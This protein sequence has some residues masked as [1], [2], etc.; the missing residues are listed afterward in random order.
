MTRPQTSARTSGRVTAWFLLACC[1]AACAGPGLH[2]LRRASPLERARAKARVE[3]GIALLVEAGDPSGA[4]AAFAQALSSDPA[5]PRIRLWA[6]WVAQLE[7]DAEGAF[8]HFLVAAQAPDPTAELAIW[9]AYRIFTTQGQAARLARVL[10]AVAARTETPALVRARALH[11]LGH[12]LR[13]LGR[14]KAADRAFARLGYLRAW[15]VIGPFDNDQNAGFHTAYPPE[16]GPI[17]L[18]QTYPGK[19]RQVGWRPVVLFAPDGRVSL[20]A[21]LDPSRWATAYLV[22]WIHSPEPK[23]VAIRLAAFR[24]VKLWLNSEP[25]LADD[26]ARV[27]ALDQYAVGARLRAGWNELLVKVCQRT[28]PW[29]LGLRLTAPDGDPVQGLRTSARA[30]PLAPAQAEGPAPATAQTFETWLSTQPADDFRAAVS[31][32]WSLRQGFSPEATRRAEAWTQARPA[33]PLAQLMLAQ[34]H[35]EAG[36]S[37][38]ALQ[39][40]AALE[41]TVAALPAALLE[42]SGYEQRNR[43]YDRA[44]RILEPLLTPGRATPAVRARQVSLLA[45]RGWHLDALREA[46]AL[47]GVQPDRAW[48]WRIIGDQYFDLLQTA[49][50]LAAYRRALAL[51]ADHKGTYDRLI[52]SDILAGRLASA[53]ALVRRRTRVFPELMSAAVQEARLLMA[54]GRPAEAL[55]VCD[56]IERIAPDFWFVH[57][58]RGDIFFWSRDRDGALSAYR[59]SLECTPNNPA[60]QEYLHHLVHQPDPVFVRYGPT[61]GELDQALAAR[62]GPQDYPEADAVLMLDDLVTHVFADGS[63]RHLV[64][65]IYRV[66]TEKGQRRLSEFRVPSS[67]SFRLEAAETIGPD[68]S[69]QEATSISA[70]VIHLPS[71]QPGSL[72]YVA[73][74]Y[75]SSSRTWMEDHYADSFT[76]QGPDPVRRARWVLA[77]PSDRKLHM[78]ERGRLIRRRMEKAGDQQVYVWTASDV[79]MLHAEPWRPP[80]RK[81]QS[82]VYVSTVP[83]WAALARWHNS[84]LQDQFEIDDA[85]R[86]KA[87]ELVSGAKTAPEKI[88]AIYRFVAKQI[89]YLD[90]DVGIFGKKPNQA[91]NVFANRFGDCKDKSTLMIAM[92]RQLGIQAYYAAVRT[93]DTGPVFWQVPYAQSNHIITFI[94]AQPGVAKP[95]FVDPTANHSDMGYLPERDQDVRALVLTGEG[96][97]LI[98]TPELGPAASMRRLSIDARIKDGQRL[99]MKVE[100]TWSGWFATR[101]RGDLSTEGKRAEDFARKVSARYPGAA[102]GSVRFSGL[103]D[104]GPEASARYSFEVPGALRREDDKLRLKLLWPLELTDRMARR[105]RRRHAFWNIWDMTSRVEVRFEVP[106]GYQVARLPAAASIDAGAFTYSLACAQSEGLVRCERKLVMP[107]SRIPPADYARFR[108]R[109]TQVDQAEQQDIVLRPTGAK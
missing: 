44:M 104:L 78:L 27:A 103:D 11:F 101:E 51:R 20:T 49:K 9:S 16:Q 45:A 68:G 32:L 17:D 83:D 105:S 90:N 69:R 57:K 55:E 97:Q 70:G 81:L 60:L 62:P 61:P 102:L 3:R 13:Y 35:F 79:P 87:A 47:A 36:R 52:T 54:A 21:L 38:N 74:R 75:N 23:D 98:D 93:R 25:L 71:L 14:F 24:G 65:Q 6:A 58:I 42:R 86:A 63:A 19:Q 106:A 18:S 76:F 50:G 100:E 109:C 33:C 84:L 48:T 30:Q 67:G 37:G 29:Q 26:Q 28:G 15:M 88:E 43:R 10:S 40:L 99:A 108:D 94:P 8:D 82:A 56:R 73:Y 22:T 1:F 66:R 46:E 85:I 72:V 59:R 107:T 2:S 95:L 5:D 96:Y 41:R 7:A 4:A 77:L 34:I 31:I 53:L 80:L 12:C 39:A 92:L 64:H 89:R 91:V